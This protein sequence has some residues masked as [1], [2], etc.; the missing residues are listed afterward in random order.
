MNDEQNFP[1]HQSNNTMMSVMVGVLTIVISIAI[2]FMLIDSTSPVA[3]A[4]A[5]GLILVAFIFCA[6]LGLHFTMHDNEG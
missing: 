3:Q 1:E 6:Y 4:V 5:F 2:L